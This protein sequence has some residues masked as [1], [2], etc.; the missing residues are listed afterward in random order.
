[1]AIFKEICEMQAEDDGLRFD[2]GTITAERITEDADYED[3]VLGLF[4]HLEN[5]RVPIQIDLGSVS[6]WFV[7]R[8][9]QRTTLLLP[10]RRLSALPRTTKVVRAPILQQR[11]L[12]PYSVRGSPRDS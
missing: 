7:T 10:C 2:A 11:Q 9:S 8:T 3:C 12:A 4:G 1:M 5:A 6:L